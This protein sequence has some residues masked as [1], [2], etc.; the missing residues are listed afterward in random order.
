MSAAT[1][2]DDMDLVL[3][4]ESFGSSQLKSTQNYHKHALRVEIEICD[5]RAGDN[6]L[7]YTVADS[8][9]HPSGQIPTFDFPDIGILWGFDEQ[10][11]RARYERIQK[12]LINLEAA[13]FADFGSR[14]D[15]SSRECLKTLF[16][17]CPSIRAPSIS[18]GS[19][20]ILTATWKGR[21]REELAIRF[22]ER[23]KI[24]FALVTRSKTDSGKLDRQWGTVHSP[25][26]FFDELPAAKAIAS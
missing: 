7:A 15:A 25:S 23:A 1:I 2:D 24:H 20:G 9:G 5:V 17:A 8:P 18:S 16:V 21:N 19:D 14:L 6:G 11:E 26:V 10:R 3:S 12:R 22:A 13:L 4:N